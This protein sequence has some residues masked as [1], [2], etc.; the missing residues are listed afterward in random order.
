MEE[1]INDKIIHKS[2]ASHIRKVKS[3]CNKDKV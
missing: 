1:K 2:L 3:F